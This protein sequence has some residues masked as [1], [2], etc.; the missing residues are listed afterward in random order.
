MLNLSTSRA[1]YEFSQSAIKLLALTIKK[2]FI[3][4]KSSVNQETKKL[5]SNQ[6]KYFVMRFPKNP[7]HKTINKYICK[8]DF[9][10]T[11]PTISP[12]GIRN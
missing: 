1:S 7:H 3:N 12:N 10:Q 4:W 9:V 6:P 2:T 5:N 11:I 8:E